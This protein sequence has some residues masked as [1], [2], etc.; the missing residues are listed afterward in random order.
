[1]Q[2]LHLLLLFV[3]NFV[4]FECVNGERKWD[5]FV[6][7]QEWPA[8]YCSIHKCKLPYKIDDFNIHGLWPGIWPYDIPTNC[9]NKTPFDIER[10]KP[11]YDELQKQWANLND[12]NHP[13]VF[14]KHEW[15]KHGVCA[16]SDYSLIL[17]ELDYFNVSLGIKSKVNLMSRLDSIKIKPNNLVTLK[18]D[19][20]LDQLKS[21]FDVNALMVCYL[22]Q[23]KPAKLSEIRF[24]L[25]PSLEFIDCPKL[26]NK[27]D[28]QQFPNNFYY[29][30]Y[31]NN[32]PVCKSL[33]WLYQSPICLNQSF[34]TSYHNGPCPEELIFP[35]FN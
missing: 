20:V 9:S 6:F 19:A 24:C 15:S 16:A 21:F 10:M 26:E 13:K 35:D 33:P 32:N 8:T 22:Q 25:N 11:I 5:Y 1:M 29:N 14:W 3:L 34:I 2:M 17:S 18:R 7:S 23:N 27:I 31:N 30:I 12:F 4:F 28:D